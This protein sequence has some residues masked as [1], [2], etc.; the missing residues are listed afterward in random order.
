[1]S[2][3][4]LV[5]KLKE[6]QAQFHLPEVQLG[7]D[8]ECGSAFDYQGG[9]LAAVMSAHLLGPLFLEYE[10]ALKQLEREVRGKAL[11]TQKQA[12][13]I[14]ALVR[15]NEEL[16]GRLEVQQREH[17]KLVEETRDN[18]DLLA[19]R[20]GSLKSAGEEDT[21]ELRNRVHLLTEENH[22]LFEQITLLRSHYDK[23][24]EEVAARIA[25]ADAK[26]QAY[27]FLNKE[28]EVLAVERDQLLQA[29][30]FLE[31]KVQETVHVLALLEEERKNDQQ[32]MNRM[33]DQL[34]VFQREYSF[35]KDHAERLEAR[36]TTELDQLQTALRDH[37]ELEKDLKMRVGELEHENAALENQ[38]RMQIV[39]MQALKRDMKQIMAINEQFQMQAQQFKERE[40]QYGE[41]AKEYKD[42]LEQVKFEREKLAIKEEQFLRQVHKLEAQAKADAKRAQERYES[43]VH[44]RQKE[45]ERALQELEDKLTRA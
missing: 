45:N 10:S 38:N 44:V 43:V 24:N 18:A 7:P 5:S 2:V 19:M 8:P 31:G 23:Y 20:T 16:A 12:E 42:K 13:E 32:E 22:V 9:E 26:S 15:E 1:V 30:V 28:F 11:E 37:Q 41:L 35:Y 29:K 17:L 3:E 25:E 33:R 4:K 34:S 14:R 39:E 21:R 40:A 6:Y 27:D 36:G